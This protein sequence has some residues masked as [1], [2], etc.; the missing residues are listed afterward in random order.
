MW[1]RSKSVYY[2]S[3]ETMT[4]PGMSKGP[5]SAQLK[6]ISNFSGTAGNSIKNEVKLNSGKPSRGQTE[7]EID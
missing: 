7:N 5:N 1:Q 3:L 6:H 2:T 4:G